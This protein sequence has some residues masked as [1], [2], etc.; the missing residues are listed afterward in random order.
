M[1]LHWDEP[2]SVTS[3]LD[4]MRG[5][6]ADATRDTLQTAVEGSKIIYD[7]ILK[8]DEDTGFA[9]RGRSG[10]LS[11]RQEAAGEKCRELNHLW[12]QRVLTLQGH[13]AAWQHGKDIAVRRAVDLA[14]EKIDKYWERTS[15]G[16]AAPTYG[17]G[18][19]LWATFTWEEYFRRI[20]VFDPREKDACSKTLAEYKH[21]IFTPGEIARIESS[22]WGVWWA[23]PKCD[24]DPV[25]FWLGREHSH[26]GGG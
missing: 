25:A 17:E 14:L 5:P 12:C 21:V 22:E 24:C 13:L 4:I 1:T 26:S 7:V 19:S 23:M 8:E 20:S 9:L 11:F 10:Y 18:D 16:Y 15:R 6:K 3:A 2:S